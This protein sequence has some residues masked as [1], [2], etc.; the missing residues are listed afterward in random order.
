[1]SSELWLGYV[2]EDDMLEPTKHKEDANMDKHIGDVTEMVRPRICEVLGVEKGE[3]F[4]AGPYKDAYIDSF[5]T[6]RTNMGTL[7]DADRVC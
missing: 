3:R 7:M 2:V 5:G 4:D 6:I 1:M